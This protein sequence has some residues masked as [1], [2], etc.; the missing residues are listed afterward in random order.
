MASGER[1]CT[2]SN[3]STVLKVILHLS[4]VLWLAA[5]AVCLSTHQ[6]TGCTRFD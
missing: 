3:P 2:F 4:Q 6:F 1:H 5:V